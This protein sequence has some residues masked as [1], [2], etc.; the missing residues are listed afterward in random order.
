MWGVREAGR[1]GGAIRL[2]LRIA[3][4]IALSAGFLFLPIE[5]YYRPSSDVPSVVTG[6]AIHTTIAS[7]AL[8][9]SYLPLTP[10]QIDRL[11]VWLVLAHVAN[12]HLYLLLPPHNPSLVASGL[13][14]LLVVGPV[15]FSWTAGRTAA[16][17]TVTCAAFA[18][19][20]SLMRSSDVV[21]GPFV[22][23]LGALAVGSGIAV[24]SARV[25][26]QLRGS[27]ARRRRELA[28]LSARLMSAQE[29]ERR[30]LSRELHDEFGQS[31]TAVNAYLWL[32]E[33]QPPGDSDGL[34]ART[35]EA[36]R[37]VSK[38][39]TAMRELSQLLRPSVLDDFGLVPSLDG[40]LKAFAER[41]QIATSFTTDGLP[42]RLPP[43]VETALYRIAQEALTNIAR[44]A[45]ASRVSVSLIARN[46]ELRLDVEDDGVGFPPRQ[47]NG[48]RVGVGLVGIR[49]RVR[50][51]GGTVTLHAGKGARLRVT[52]PL[53]A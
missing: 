8:I 25:L 11:V 24:A 50:A 14:C 2:R 34:R 53:P 32:I 37:V 30:R 17:A 40:Q 49:E 41:H 33:R 48:G 13:I 18:A 52:L 15:F 28:S 7:F 4:L 51:L 44:H 6:W 21:D 5:G 1:H 12:A 22:A 19:V 20:G 39:L 45:R 43:E 23:A 31:L 9:A 47:A 10:L 3:A 26:G 35:A 38:T 16:I 42:E 29:E 27:L 36:R 46:G